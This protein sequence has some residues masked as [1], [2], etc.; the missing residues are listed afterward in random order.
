MA[1]RRTER[2]RLLRLLVEHSYR[3]ADG[4]TF[5]LASGKLSDF[6]VDCRATTMRAEA[7]PLIGAV[8]GACVPAEADAIGGLTMG[9][10]PIAMATAYWAATR[11]RC[12][13]AFSVRKQAKTH[14]LRKWVEGCVREGAKVVVVDDVITTGRSTIEAIR[15]CREESLLVVAVIALVDREEE[16]GMAAVRRETGPGVPVTAVF[17]RADLERASRSSASGRGRSHAAH[18]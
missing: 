16:E 12:L 9:A 2:D 1:G 4:P 3:K 14:G 17:T 10:D 7:M 15:R 18:G 6:Y 11:G 5:R 13:N 8:V